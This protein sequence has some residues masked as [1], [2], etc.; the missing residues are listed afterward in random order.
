M[1]AI[2]YFLYYTFVGSNLQT[3]TLLHQ[4]FKTRPKN[5]EQEH[6]SKLR[7]PQTIRQPSQLYKFLLNTGLYFWCKTCLLR[8]RKDLKYERMLGIA[9]KRVEQALDLRMLIKQS[10]MIEVLLKQVFQPRHLNLLLN[11]AH[12]KVIPPSP[13]STTHQK[14]SQFFF[15]FSNDEEEEEDEDDKPDTGLQDP[16]VDYLSSDTSTRTKILYNGTI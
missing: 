2:G 12:P 11:Q 16:H 8:S 15:L 3:Y 5:T 7:E 9:S 10:S 1:M 14:D 4:Y 6:S 13:T